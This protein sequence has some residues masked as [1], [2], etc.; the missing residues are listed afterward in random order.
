MLNPKSVIGIVGS[1]QLGR[2]LSISAAQLGFKT[3]IFTPDSKGPA[4]QVSSFSTIAD[5][6]DQNA[7]KQFAKNCDFITYEFENIPIA[8]ARY[9]EQFCTLSP[10][11][12]ILE[13]TQDRLKEKQFLNQYGLKTAPYYEISSLNDLI[14]TWQTLISQTPQAKAIL[15]TRHMGYDG[16][17]Q[18]TIHTLED[19][20]NAWELFKETPVILEE[21]IHFNREISLLIA[22]NINNQFSAYDFV[23]NLHENQ[24]LKTSTAPIDI[25]PDIKNTCFQQVQ[26]FMTKIEYKGLMAIEFFEDLNGKFIANEIAPRV[27]NSGHWTEAACVCSQFEQHIRSIADWHFG[28]VTP[29]AKAHMVNLIGKEVENLSQLASKQ[30]AKLHIYGK[31][32]T[33]KGRKMGHITYLSPLNSER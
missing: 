6:E 14:S 20:I 18:K 10:N 31:E 15:K 27:H 7:L 11:A 28:D 1:G 24:I 32:E 33:K 23:E 30:S 5:Y 2:M 9:L 12:D 25:D 29:F 8:S 4:L 3:H 17:G 19:C 21:F 22:R 13:I 26:S 16:K